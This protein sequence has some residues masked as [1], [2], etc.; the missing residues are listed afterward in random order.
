[1]R[2]K[3]THNTPSHPKVEELM[4]HFVPRFGNDQDIRIIE[5]Y[6]KI[7]KLLSDID[8]SA[9]RL[10]QIKKEESKLTSKMKQIQTKEKHLFYMLNNRI[11]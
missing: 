11:L 3:K 2:T 7:K 1:M 9:M 4:A 10:A 6:G 8:A 5:E